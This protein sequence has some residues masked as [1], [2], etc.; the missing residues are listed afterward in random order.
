VI[1]TT[2]LAHPTRTGLVRSTA[3]IVGICVHTSE[4]GEGPNSAENLA[5]FTASPRTASNL[6]SYHAIADTD[7]VILTV[8]DGRQAYSAGGGNRT[9]LHICIPGRV[10][11]TR[12]QWLDDVSRAAI[13][14]VA[15]YIVEKGRQYNIPFHKL[16]VAEVQGGRARG[17]CG[18][19]DISW[20]FGQSTHTDPYP[21]F[22]WDVL[23]ADIAALSPP[24]P[25]PVPVFDPANGKYGDAPFVSKRDC[26][27][28]MSGDDVRYAKGVQRDHTARFLRWFSVTQPDIANG[29]CMFVNPANGQHISARRGDIWT[30]AIA[31]SENLDPNDPLFEGGLFDSILLTQGSLD[32]CTIEGVALDFTVNGAIDQTMWS[33]IDALSDGTWG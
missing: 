14:Q 29:P 20:A 8:P 26:H 27:V 1:T 17:Y 13:R 6:A 19:R 30:L 23:E 28:F 5:A 22:P 12:E 10:S 9:Y 11:Q 24:T 31:V 2:V 25:E 33:F 7:K 15:E 21:N 4:G 3:Q 32:Q 16:T 18:H